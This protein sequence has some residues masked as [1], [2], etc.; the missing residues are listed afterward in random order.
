MSVGSLPAS[1]PSTFLGLLVPLLQLVL[2]QPILA[3]EHLLA[4]V[5]LE[6]GGSRFT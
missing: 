6:L 5:A 1:L 4:L 2:G 3:G